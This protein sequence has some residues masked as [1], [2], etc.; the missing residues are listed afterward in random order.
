MLKIGWKKCPYCGDYE[1]YRS[2]SKPMSWLDRYCG[3]FLL[4]LVRCRECEL[5]HYRPLAFPAP[6]CPGNMRALKSPPSNTGDRSQMRS[7]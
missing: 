2:R 6:E 7:A 5:R 1:V 3:L 4:H